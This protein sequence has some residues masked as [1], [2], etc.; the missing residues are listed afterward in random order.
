MTQMLIFDT[1]E[2]KIKYKVSQGTGTHADIQEPL[3]LKAPSH[4]TRYYTSLHVINIVD[5]NYQI[6]RKTNKYK[7]N[8]FSSFLESSLKTDLLNIFITPISRLLIME[9]YQSEIQIQTKE[10]HLLCECLA[11]HYHKSLRIEIRRQMLFSNFHIVAVKQ[12]IN[13]ITSRNNASILNFGGGFRWQSE[14]PWYIIEVKKSIIYNIITKYPMWSGG[15]EMPSQQNIIL[16]RQ[17]QRGKRSK[18]TVVV[19]YDS[20][21]INFNILFLIRSLILTIPSTL[22]HV[23][24]HSKTTYVKSY[25]KCSRLLN[26][27]TVNN[28]LMSLK[29]IYKHFQKSHLLNS[30]QEKNP[31]YVLWKVL[32]FSNTANEVLS[33]TYPRMNK[34]TEEDVIYNNLP[35]TGYEHFEP[36]NWL[37]TKPNLEEKLLQS[38]K[39]L[40]FT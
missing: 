30:L 31:S 11:M 6:I 12:Q 37:I 2:K 34:T 36:K 33:K 14:Y 29:K 25:T 23:V 17:R 32:I 13:N 15:R 21:P 3:S 5:N 4:R 38:S 19:C 16:M 18:L 39:C 10:K 20:I 40:H 26:F 8:H 27:D 7:N 28:F 1:N 22:N 24:A 35:Y 9:N